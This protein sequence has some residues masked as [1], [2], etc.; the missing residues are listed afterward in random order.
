MYTTN[1]TDLTA[2]KIRPNIHI[3]L[4][5]ISLK[6]NSP[7]WSACMFII[8][9]N[10]SFFFYYCL[11]YISKFNPTKWS[12]MVAPFPYA[13]HRTACRLTLII[14]P[15]H[16]SSSQHIFNPFPS[17]HRPND[18]TICKIFRILFPYIYTLDFFFYF[19]ICV[20]GFLY[21]FDAIRIFSSHFRVSF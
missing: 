17:H 20:Y 5:N 2:K 16:I 18:R 1:L 10:I 8:L 21:R 11:L 4:A 19:D 9:R 15:F 7:K 12:N 6:K 13:P 14:V 3:E